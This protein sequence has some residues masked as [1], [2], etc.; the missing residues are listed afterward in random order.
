MFWNKQRQIERLEGQ[1]EEYKDNIVGLKRELS[2]LR[3]LEA[4]CEIEKAAMAMSHRYA[5]AENEASHSREIFNLNLS[6]ETMMTKLIAD[7][8]TGTTRLQKKVEVLERDF[9]FELRKAISKDKESIRKQSIDQDRKYADKVKK[10]EAEYASKM[11]KL[12]TKL[13]QDKASYRKYL[14]Q[15]NNTKIDTLEKENKRLVVENAILKGQNE[16]L[17]GSQKFFAGKQESGG[18]IISQLIKALPTVSAE[19]TTPEINVVGTPTSA[20]KQNVG[21]SDTQKKN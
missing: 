14:R 16:V 10:L 7:H 15:E 5:I 12:D 13:E 17:N 3:N 2:G 6:Q 21:G 18:E 8:E 20:P 19:I 1:V 9:N 4:N 11:S